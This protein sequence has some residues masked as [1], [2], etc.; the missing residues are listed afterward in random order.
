MFGPVSSLTK[1]LETPHGKDGISC[2]LKDEASAKVDQI[3]HLWSSPE[4]VQIYNVW[5]RIAHSD[6]EL[7]KMFVQKIWSKCM[8][9][10]RD[11]TPSLQADGTFLKKNKKR[12]PNDQLGQ[13]SEPL[14]LHF[15]TFVLIMHI[16]L[17]IWT[18]PRSAIQPSKRPVSSEVVSCCAQPLSLRNEEFE[19]KR[20]NEQQRR[21][22][23]GL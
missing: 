9:R 18:F 16:V 11:Q 4:S 14:F 5:N 2:F 19:I 8:K 13:V 15:T 3:Q 20:R 10:W 1:W 7:N 17:S 21:R 6:G 22:W 23:S 12:E